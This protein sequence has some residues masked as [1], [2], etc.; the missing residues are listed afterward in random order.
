MFLPDSESPFDLFCYHYPLLSIA[1][2]YSYSRMDCIP[3]NLSQVIILWF[4]VANE[5]NDLQWLTSLTRIFDD[6][7]NT[8]S[9]L[10]SISNVIKIYDI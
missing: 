8:T 2:I 9:G 4:S 1:T 7:V 5:M 10:R 3:V 6:V